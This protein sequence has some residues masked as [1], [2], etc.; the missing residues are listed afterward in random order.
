MRWLHCLWCVLAASAALAEPAIKHADVFRSGA[1]GYHSYRIPAIE[2][3]ADGSLAAF[4]EA[5]KYNLG[6]PGMD[7]N[8]IDLVIKRST[9]GGATWSAM[10][11]IEDPG[12]RWS[13]ANPAT[14]V[15]RQTGRMW[16]LYLRCKPNRDTDSSRPGTDD[17]QTLARWSDDHGATWSEPVD[18]T[19]VARDM[20]DKTWKA[21]VVGPGGA[22]QDAKGRLIAPVWKNAPM[23]TLA[24]FSDDHGKTWR[25][26]T[27]V[28]GKQGGDEDQIVELADGR[29]LMDFRQNRGPHRFMSESGDGGK[30]W[31]EPRPGNPVTPVCCAIE[32]FTRKSAGD[33]RDRILWTGPK[34]PGRMNLVVRVSYDEG[35]TFPHE[36]PIA[37]G[38]A[39]YSD[40]TVLKDK[41]IGVLWERG[42]ERGYQYI[43][44]T[45]FT[46]EHLEPA[47]RP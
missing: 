41:S 42:A 8:D 27:I 6:D 18:L 10:K 16:L 28:P 34:G 26:G 45:R 24:I 14:V 33:D 13:A 7:K 30:T 3:A 15:D 22:I 4:A 23:Q 31:S 25:R 11:V 39:A 17:M 32:R 2:T 9:D 43:T 35:K 46:R 44:F 29:L 38:H 19:A 12:E 37:S 1:D 47:G 36:R 20:A 21:S 40:L 5:R